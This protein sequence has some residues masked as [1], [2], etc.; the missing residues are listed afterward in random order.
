MIRGVSYNRSVTKSEPKSQKKPPKD[1]VLSIRLSAE[2]AR[3]LDQLADKAGTPVSTIVR[4]W[5]AA[6][7]AQHRADSVPGVFEFIAQDLQ[8]L[9]ALIRQ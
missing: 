4:D 1:R 5:I 2:E 9:R 6:G 7:L 8:R 3:E